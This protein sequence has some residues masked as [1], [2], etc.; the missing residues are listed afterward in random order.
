MSKLSEKVAAFYKR[1]PTL[2]KCAVAGR[3]SAR[4][5][6]R[7][8][9]LRPVRAG[10]NAFTRSACPKQIRNGPCGGTAPTATAKST[11]TALNLVADD[12]RS[13]RLEP[14]AQPPESTTPST[15]AWSTP[16]RGWTCSPAG[17]SQWTY[18]ELQRGR[19]S[20]QGRNGQGQESGSEATA[21][22]V[23]SSLSIEL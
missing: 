22:G 21:E 10:Y 9:G 14:E 17:F 23:A 18:E 12:K 19:G 16:A 1:H 6:V 13:K 20:G 4:S 8:P 3:M 5:P 2:Y 11:P 15:I 7:V